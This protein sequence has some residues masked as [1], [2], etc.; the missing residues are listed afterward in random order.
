[1]SPV[2]PPGPPTG[3]PAGHYPGPYPG[4][5]VGAPTGYPPYPPA[6]PPRRGKRTGWT[7]AL[8]LGALAVLVCCGAPAA[9]GLRYA[10]LANGPYKV[11]PN[12]CATTNSATANRLKAGRP[13]NPEM[14]QVVS[15]QPYVGCHWFA[16]GVFSF[17]IH[18]Q[19]YH[20]SATKDSIDKSRDLYQFARRTADTGA[21]VRDAYG[22]GDQAFLMLDD[23]YGTARFDATVRVAN[24]HIMIK[25]SGAPAKD[26]KPVSAADRDAALSQFE[27]TAR[28]LVADVVEDL[29]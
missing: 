20:K 11:P 18:V 7:V 8:V 14:D 23:R 27:S 3:P 21:T 1:M 12:L 25:Y 15:S 29:H 5:H 17:M 19:I 28:D 24:A 4:P 6:T 16:Q 9:F 2:Q 22:L 10:L 26:A 13:P